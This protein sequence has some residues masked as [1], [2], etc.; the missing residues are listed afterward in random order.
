MNI[1][2]DYQNQQ[3]QQYQQDIF[4]CN[5]K[6]DSIFKDISCLDALTE[7]AIT[8]LTEK[9]P[10]Y[11]HEYEKAFTKQVRDY[12][13][14]LIQECKSGTLLKLSDE[15]IEEAAEN[16][17][18]DALDASCTLDHEHFKAGFQFGALMMV[19]LLI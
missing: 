2:Q 15:A 13:V 7:Y 3:S 10:S 5:S 18:G 1:Q 6:L 8:A 16:R 17:I 19:Q 12:G 4:P 11:F 14:R 9:T